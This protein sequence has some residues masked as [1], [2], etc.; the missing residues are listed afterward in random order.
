MGLRS[1]LVSFLVIATVS[2]CGPGR[3]PG[4]QGA[5]ARIATVVEGGAGSSL[6]M[7][8]AAPFEWD[9]FCAFP[10]YTT[11]EAA[12]G[13]LGF[14]WPHAWS[15][16]DLRDDRAY[17]VFVRE[18]RVVSAFDYDRSRGDFAALG[19]QCFERER[20]RFVVAERGVSTTGAPWLELHPAP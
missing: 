5:A 19:P 20:A 17:L 18:G 6:D 14:E 12:G 8:A 2:A 15:A 13:T 9:R 3:P 7:A 11:A 10:P 1:A 4:D 16:V